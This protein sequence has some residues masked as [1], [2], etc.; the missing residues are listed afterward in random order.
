MLYPN[1]MNYL[2]NIIGAL[3]RPALTLGIIL[4]MIA[5]FQDTIL[6]WILTILLMLLFFYE[7]DKASTYLKKL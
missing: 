4:I 1:T 6:D 3:M 7:M 5:S 2:A